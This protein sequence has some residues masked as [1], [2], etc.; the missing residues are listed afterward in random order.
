MS[1]SAITVAMC[2]EF[3]TYDTGQVCVRN[4]CVTVNVQGKYLPWA[5]VRADADLP[6]GYEGVCPFPESGYRIAVIYDLLRGR[7]AK[8]SVRLVGP[9]YLSGDVDLLSVHDPAYVAHARNLGASPSLL[10]DTV[11]TDSTFSVATLAAQCCV[12]MALLC[13]KQGSPCLAIVRPPGHHA[14]RSSPD[15]FCVFNNAALAARAMLSHGVERVLIWDWDIHHGHGTQSVFFE[16]DHVL[17]A[18]IHADSR[19][20]EYPPGNQD[21]CTTDGVGSGRG[22]SV[23]LPLPLGITDAEY[24]ALVEG[25]LMPIFRSFAPEA[26]VVSAGFDA[27]ADGLCHPVFYSDLP[28]FLLSAECFAILTHRVL[29]LAKRAAFVLEGGYSADAVAAGVNEVVN[30]VR[31]WRKGARQKGGTAFGEVRPDI[32]RKVESYQR[33]FR[34]YWPCL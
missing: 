17:Y 18:S 23:N 14:S 5:S 3:Q 13:L 12:D 1:E 2:D 10:A 19:I 30:T 9:L 6:C 20:I 33:Y 21:Q 4:G 16:S 8:N 22:F 27:H 32:E 25:V 28:G 34:R 31:H 11:F 24:L 29:T 26:I 15:G 7:N